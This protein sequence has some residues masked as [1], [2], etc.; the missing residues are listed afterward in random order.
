MSKRMELGKTGITINRIGLGAN[1]VGGH[2]LYR[3]LS[4]EIGKE[5]V[6]VAIENG[7]DF[8]D[9]AYAYGFGRSEELIGEVVQALGNREEVVLATKGSMKIV[10]EK[11]VNDN[12]PAFLKQAVEDSL[13]RLNTDYI[14]LFYIH[15]PD[16]KTPPYEAVGALKELK[17]QGKIRA[18]GV[19][20]F[21]LEQLKE[22]NQDG[23]VD[24]YQGGYNL[25]DRAAEKEFFPYTLENNIAFIPFFPLAAGLLAGKY[26]KHMKFNDFRANKPFFQGKEFEQN[27][28]KVEQLREIAN[29]KRVEVAHLVLA[30]YLTQE[31]VTA[32]IPGAKRAEQV[33]DNLKSLEVQLTEDGIAKIDEI[34]R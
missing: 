21:T 8:I 4:E 11:V 6:R 22:A 29:E 19:S 12:S 33:L 7:V 30:W 10:G 15:Q 3:D 14:D 2:N 1:A 24:V 34:F 16:G 25:I 32:L 13:K 28:E 9:T 20:N 17:D 31:A 5:L 26:N 18:I 23:Y 27:L